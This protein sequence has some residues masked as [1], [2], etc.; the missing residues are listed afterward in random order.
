VPSVLNL[1]ALLAES[2]DAADRAAALVLLRRALELGVTAEERQQIEEFLDAPAD[3]PDD[4]V[5]EGS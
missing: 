3:A 4:G 1:A 5:G 2:T